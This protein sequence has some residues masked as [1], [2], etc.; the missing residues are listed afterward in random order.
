VRREGLIKGLQY[1]A[2][3]GSLDVIRLILDT[4]VSVDS[5]TADGAAALMFAASYNQLEAARLLLDKGA[6]VNHKDLSGDTALSLAKAPEM[7]QLLLK[8]GAAKP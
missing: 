3:R 5:S 4:G 8:R 1:A 7:R 6:N 2:A